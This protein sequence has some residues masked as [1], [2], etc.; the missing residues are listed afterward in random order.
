MVRFQTITQQSRGSRNVSSTLFERCDVE[1][2][3]NQ[4]YFNPLCLQ[5]IY[6]NSHIYE[7]RVPYVEG[8]LLQSTFKNPEA[9]NE[10]GS[11]KTLCLNCVNINV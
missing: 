6:L 2:T 1:T 10:S 3:L 8:I 7:Y 4:V 9:A 11:L 5:V